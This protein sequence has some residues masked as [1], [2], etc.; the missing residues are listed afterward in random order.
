MENKSIEE[1]KEYQN[2]VI[3]IEEFE[4]LE[5][6]KNIELIQFAGSELGI[7]EYPVSKYN[8]LLEDKDV[9]TIYEDIPTW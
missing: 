7:R 2:K 4:K 3:S 6:N 5:E 1:L 9:I 8:I